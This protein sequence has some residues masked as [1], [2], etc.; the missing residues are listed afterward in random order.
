MKQVRLE[1]EQKGS[2]SGAAA[3][4]CQDQPLKVPEQASA[5]LGESLAAPSDCTGQ[6]DTRMTHH[7]DH[8]S[9]S[10]MWH[11]LLPITDKSQQAAVGLISQSVFFFLLPLHF[12]IHFKR[13]EVN[14]SG[15]KPV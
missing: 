15:T 5:I 7:W 2:V 12:Q 6:P 3:P 8:I 1:R 13:A 9:T 4:T 14:L 11:L 10:V